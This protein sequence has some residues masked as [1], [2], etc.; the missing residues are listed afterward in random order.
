M[1]K[2]SDAAAPPAAASTPAAAKNPSPSTSNN[3]TAASNTAAGEY[4]LERLRVLLARLQTAS[5][6]LQTWPETQGDSAKVHADTAAKLIVAI[7]RVALGARGVERHV[8]G[9]GPA[10]HNAAE[11]GESG[12]NPQQHM[13]PEALAAFRSSLEEKCPVPLDLLDLLDVGQPFGMHPQCYSRHTY[14]RWK[15]RTSTFLLRS[16]VGWPRCPQSTVVRGRTKDSENREVGDPS[17][18]NGRG[19]IL[20]SSTRYRTAL[21]FARNASI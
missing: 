18:N 1:A 4:L 5:E 2:S 20:G 6:I 3:N 17:G 16:F 21:P 13:S 7:R 15:R 19:A 8:N 14:T 9:T 11:K 10:A 12:N